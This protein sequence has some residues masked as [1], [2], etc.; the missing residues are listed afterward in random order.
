MGRKPKLRAQAREVDGD[1]RIGRTIFMQI[2]RQISG[3]CAGLTPRHI[4]THASKQSIR[5]SGPAKS[6]RRE[7]DGF[8]ITLVAIFLLFVVGAM[9]ALSIDVVTFYTARSEAQLA[10]DSGALAGARVL[11]NSGATSDSSGNT[12]TAAQLIA[13]AVATQV[14]ESNSVGG[15]PLLAGNISVSFNGNN[16]SPCPQ[17][18]QVSNPCVTVQI[19]TT[20]P[21]FFARIWGNTQVTISAS[22]TAE[23]YNPSG[24]ATGASSSQNIPIAPSCVK[25]WLLPN[26]DPTSSAGNPTP[27]FNKTFGTI[28]NSALLGWE[29]PNPRGSIRFYARCDG[30][31]NCNGSTG[32]AAAWQYF[33]GD[34]S[35]FPQPTQSVPSCTLTTPFQE[36]IAGCV[37]T[38]IACGTTS[39]GSVPSSQVNI[40][41]VDDSSLNTQAAEAVNC[42]AHLSGGKGDTISSTMMPPTPFEFTAGDDNPLVQAGSLTSEKETM[43]SDSLVTVPVFDSTGTPSS[44]VTVIGFVQLFLQPNGKAVS[45]FTTPQY[46]IRTKIINLVGCGTNSTG[47]PPVYGNGATAVPVRLISPP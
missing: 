32:T 9:A 18:Q 12:F 27:I 46:G 22:A 47:T 14:A 41:F 7:T 21:V 30:N 44:P 28:E 23:A 16:G 6:R 34:N 39:S 1:S 10:A 19:T 37:Q 33:V 36:S 38:P 2:S 5:R 17:A 29:T 13:G 45:G 40:D 31:G 42:L 4:S 24:L 35:S 8:I 26:I 25:P 3:H 20:V 11:A 43:V 15:Q